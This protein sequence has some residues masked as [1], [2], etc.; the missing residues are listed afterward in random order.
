[1]SRALCLALIAVALARLVVAIP[2]GVASAP[3]ANPSQYIGRLYFALVEVPILTLT[4]IVLGTS[5]EPRPRWRR[6]LPFAL[7]TV[8]LVAMVLDVRRG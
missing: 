7:L 4:F 5:A 1:M 8:S 2:L 6:V 3:P